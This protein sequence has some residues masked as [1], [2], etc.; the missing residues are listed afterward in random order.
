MVERKDHVGFIRRELTWVDRK[1]L[2]VV[3][4]LEVLVA[5]MDLGCAGKSE[6]RLEANAELADLLRLVFLGA[7]QDV[8]DRLDISR[9]ES[10]GAVVPELQTVGQQVEH[11]ALRPGVFGIL[12]QLIDE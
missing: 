8:T 11:N 5:R 4:D 1:R 10:A 7:P 12:E 3:L 6:N 2:N 9:V